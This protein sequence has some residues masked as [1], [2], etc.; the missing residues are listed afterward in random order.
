MSTGAHIEFA[1]AIRQWLDHLAVM[2]RSPK[3]ISTYG[4]ALAHLDRYLIRQGIGRPADVQTRHLEDWRALLHATACKPAT[5]ELFVRVARG[6]CRWL[7]ASG[8][9]FLDPAKSLTAPRIP[10]T[11]GRFPTER[12]M[13]ELLDGIG[14]DDAFSLRDRAL[15]ETAYASAARRSELANLNLASV[16]RCNGLLRIRGKGEQERV[17]PLTQCASSAIDRYLADARPIFSRGQDVPALFLGSKRGQRLSA[18][19]VARVIQRRAALAGFYLA[20]HGI[21]RSV[22]TQMVVAGAPLYHV[23]DLLGHQT[24]R[25]LGRYSLLPSTAVLNVVRQSRL[26]R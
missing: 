9:I 3:T 1:S 18:V 10:R 22:A 21:R 4:S 13:R 15:I 5:V 23:K 2:R 19:G 25:H 14:G 8:R 20:P 12:Q 11:V 7:A 26:N 16:D 17:V 6:W 24:F